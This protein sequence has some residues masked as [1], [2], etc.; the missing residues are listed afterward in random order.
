MACHNPHYQDQLKWVG[1]ATE[2]YLVTGTISGVTYNSALEQTTITYANATT[3]TNWPA[4][5]ALV[6]DPDWTNKSVSHPNR[7]LVLVHDKTATANTFIILS[8]TATQVVVKGKLDSNA[9]DPSYINPQTQEQNSPS[10]NTFGL[11]Y[12]DL[13]RDS[14]NAKPVKFF[15]PNGGFVEAGANTTG[16]C[17]VCHTATTRFTNDGT[18]PTGSDSHSSRVSGNCTSCHKHQDGFKG[19]SHDDTSF[20]WAGNCATCHNPNNTVTSIVNEIHG[21]CGLCHVDPAGGGARKDGDAAYGVDGSATGATNGSSCV[22]CHIAKLGLTAGGIHH[23]SK[24][25]YAAAADC[26]QCHA[27]TSGKLAAN[28]TAMVQGDANCVDCHTATAGTTAGVPVD[29][30]NAK[31]H[32]ACTTCHE[33]SG[34]LK[35]AYGLATAMPT[36]GTGSNDGGG[37][38]GACHGSYFSNHT[39]SHTLN[40][41]SLCLNCHV[42]AT[43][44]FVAAGEA[45]ANGCQTCHNTTT[46]ALVGDASGKGSGAD[47]TTCHSGY[48]SNHTHS[49]TMATVVMCVSCHTN[50]TAAPYVATGQIHALHGCTT[51]HSD[52]TG[53]LIGSATSKKGVPGLNCQTCHSTYFDGHG[54]DH[55][56][57]VQVNSATTPAVVNCTNCHV[58][59]A[60]PFVGDGEVHATLRCQSCHSNLN[61]TLIGSALG[62]APGGECG[63]CHTA[64]FG[65]HGHNHLV[66]LQGTD[67]GQAAPGASC[68]NCHTVGSWYAINQLHGAGTC[69]TCHNATRTTGNPSNPTETIGDVI[70]AN[71]NPTGCLACHWAKKS[72]AT[73][74]GH[75]ATAFVWTTA[76]QNSCGVAACHDSAVNANLVVNVHGNNCALCHVDPDHGNYTRRAGTDG[77]AIGVLKDTGASCDACHSPATYAT[78]TT[79]HD[80]ANATSGTCT[81]C[82]S[83]VTYGGNH[84]TLVVADSNCSGCHGGTAGTSTG[85]P[86]SASDNKVHDACTT[87]H[88]TTG[89]LKAAYGKAIAMPDGGAGSNNGGGV[90]TACHGSY[91]SN[92]VNADHST[93]VVESPNCSLC[94]PSP[95]IAG[96]VTGVPVDPANNKVHDACSTCHETNGT[97][98]AA[99]GKASAMPAGGGAC[100]ACHGD[101]FTKHTNANHS[102]RVLDTAN[103]NNCHPAATIAGTATGV[104]VDVN[105]NMVH[106]ACT[107]C[108]ATNGSLLAA[109]GKASTM[110]VGGGDCNA[111]HGL[112]FVNHS[113]AN[114]TTRVAT[115]ANCDSCHPSASIAGTTTGVPVSPTNNKVHDA[116]AT[117]HD[118]T[119]G[120]L[121]AAYG[122]ATAMPAGGGAC[123]ACHGSSFS[124]HSHG[125][126]MS[127][128]A[129]CTNCH[130]T[131][132]T[133]PFAAAGQ[134]H[135]R[136]GCQT[137]HSATGQLT[138]SAIG[139]T[140]GANCQTC[141]STYFNGHGHTHTMSTVGLCVS[142][143]TTATLAPY[144]A[145]GQTHNRLGCQ[146]CHSDT[147]GQRI[148]VAAGKGAGETCQTCHTAYFDGHGHNHGS[149]VK[150]NIATTPNTANCIGCHTATTAPFVAAGQV[151]AQLGCLSCH[152]STDGKLRG[153]ATEHTSGG[154]CSTCHSAYFNGH[155][156]HTGTTHAVLMRG[157]DLS[158]GAACNSCH[159]IGGVG[160]PKFTN[161]WGGASGIYAVH[162]SD[163]TLCHNS[164]RTTNVKVGYAGVQAII[165]DN[166]LDIGCLD[167]HGDRA[168]THGG[169]GSGDFIWDAAS[170]SGCGAA[171]C[172]NS[173]LNT[174]VVSSIHADQCALCHVSPTTG[175]Y[176]R[177]AGTDG[178]SVGAAVG[179]TCTNCHNSTTF[180]K[181]MIHHDT[182]NAGNGNCTV[183]HNGSTYGGNHTPVVVTDSNC[184]TCHP[185]TAGTAN[186]ILVSTSDN[187]VHDACTTCHE[188][189]GGLKAAYGKAIAMPAGGSASNDGGGTC[190]A[191]HGSYFP[192]HTNANHTTRVVESTNCNL[193]HLSAGIA[194]TVTG[195]P[196]DP[197]NNKVHDACSTCHQANGDLKAAYGKASAMPQGGGAC[198][199]CHG[200]Y[201][202][203]HASANH[204]A[205][206]LAD[207]NCV[208][209]HTGTAGTTSG[210]P[211]NAA[212]AKVHDGCSTCHE[213]NGALKAAYGQA[214]AMPVGGSGSNDGGGACSACHGSYFVSHSHSHT[215]NTVSL[216]LNCHVAAAAPYVVTGQ[217]HGIRGCQT[218]HNTTTGALIGDATGKTSG[219]DCSTCHGGYFNG[220]TH[221]HIMD[222]VAMCVSCHTNATTA[223]YSASGQIHAQA[224]CQ[225]CHD[226]ST[227]VLKGSATGKKGVTGI[228]CQTCH[229]AYF[230]GHSH[231]H[232][233][234]VKVNTATTPAVANCSNCHAATATPF[235]GVGQV[236]ATRGC[237]SC[238][239][240]LNGALVGSAQGKSPGGEC[241]D[242][243]TAYFSGHGHTHTVSLQATDL[244][245]A[246]PGALCTNCHAVGSWYATNQLHGL[247]TCSTC[248]NATRTTGNPNN[249]TETIQ[250]VI[251]ANA[252]PTG[253]LACHWA[254][255][256]PAT[257]GGH[258]ATAFVWTTTTQNSCGI[259]AC[260]NSAVNTNLVVDVHGNNCALC[261]VDPDHG[262][263]T[264]RAGTDGSA[265]GVLKDTGATC[266]ACH[267]TPTY[268]TGT[269]HHDTANAVSGACSAC[270]SG[271]TYGGNHTTL[272]AVDSDCSGCHAGTA[273]TSSGVP[274]STGDN[275]IHDTC[276]TCHET[277]GALKVAYGKAIAMPNGGAGSNNGGGNCTA[278]HGAY[279]V[280]HSNAN[281][282][283]R[284]AES[285]NCNLCHPTASIVG[286]TTGVPVEPA[287]NKVHD[288]CFTCHQSNG[289]LKAAYGNASAMPSG[290]G[291]CEACHGV[292]F[293]NHDN[294][295]HTTRVVDTAN[296]NTCHLTAT[297]AGTATGVPVDVADNKVHDNCATCHATNGSLRTAYGKVSAMPAG[298]GDCNACHGIYF[299]NHANANHTTR[300]ATSSTCDSC[301][302]PASI[303]GTGSGI[304]VDPVNN[305][306]HD[307]CTTCHN[308]TTGALLAAYGKASAMPTGGGT[309]VACH[310]SYFSG[311][312]H[313]HTMITVALCT[314]CHTTAT[315][316][317]YV[318]SGQ[319]HNR[320]GCQTCHSAT[321]GLLS[322]SAAGMTAGATCQTC[323]STYFNAHSHNH[324]MNTVAL[325]VSCHTTAT[326]APYAA[327]GQTHGRL[328]CQT[329]H[330]NTTGALSGA[331]AGQSANA[332]CQTCHTAYFNGHGHNHGTSVKVNSV[333]SVVTANCIGCHSATSAPFVGAGQ[334]H[335][336]QGCQSCHN[337]TDGKLRGSAVGHPVGGECSICHSTYFNGHTQHT[338]TTH[339]VLMRGSD[340]SGGVACNS[341]HA[342]G[343][344]GTPKFT[345]AWGGAAGIYALHR[346][347]CTLCHDS[348]R[349]INVKSGY[350]SVQAII[351]DN[352]LSI[353]CLDCH[354]DRG[355]TH[356]G[357]AAT[358]FIWDATS[359]SGCGAAACHNSGVNTDV[360][361]AIHGGQCVLC[362]TSPTTGDY[363]RRVGTDGTAVAA[364]L[365]AT[366]TTCHNSTTYPKGMIHHDTANATNGN[367]TSCHNG[368]T[369]GGNHTLL[370]NMNSNCATCH[371]ATA[372][373]A[374]GVPLSVADNKVHDACTTC[375][376]T[377][378]VLKAAYGSAIAMPAGTSASNDGGGTCT[379]CH[380]AYF[381]SHVN[382]NHTLR[383][384]DHSDCNACHTAT[385][386]TATTVPLSVADNKIHDTCGTCHDTTAGTLLAATTTSTTPVAPL[387]AWLSL[388][389]TAP[390]AVSSTGT[391]V[392]NVSVSAGSNR[393]LI[394]AVAMED[395]S[396]TSTTPT[397]GVTCGGTLLTPIAFGMSPTGREHAWLGYLKEGQIP[398]GS[399]PLSVSFTNGAQNVT[400]LHVK[401][402]SYLGVD[403][404]APIYGSAAT[405]NAA[406][407]VT[408]GQ[409]VNYLTSGKTLFVAVNG[410]AAATIPTPVSG[411]GASEAP[412]TANGFTS[413]ISQTATHANG[414]TYPNNT[415]V[416]FGGTTAAYS[417]IAVA[418][419]K[420]YTGS[421]TNYPDVIAIAPGTCVTCHGA[422]FTSHT[423]ADHTAMVAD[424]G[425]CNSC[426]PATA[427]AVT[428]VPVNASD[429]KVHDSCATCHDT[430]GTLKAAYGKASAMPVGGGDCNAC[431]GNYFATHTNANHLTRVVSSAN[432][433]TCHP[434]VSIAGTLTGIPV[435][436]A[437][438]KVHDA[439]S[440]CHNNTTG[441]LLA[442]YG[443]AASMPAGGGACEVCHSAYFAN[444]TH[445]H[446]LNTV[447]ICLNCHV[448]AAA[449]FA[450]AGEAHKNGC[451]TCHNTSTGALIGSA[452]GKTA[453]ADCQTCHS[454][455]FNSHG[456][457]HTMGTVAMCVSCHTTA[458]T[459]PYTAVAQTHAR[460]GCQT[461]HNAT[462]GALNGSATGKLSGA[463]CQTCHSTYFNGHAKDHSALVKVNTDVSLPVANCVNCHVATTAP[464]IGSG[465]AHANSSCQ[466]CHSTLNGTLQGSAVSGGGECITCHAAYFN[467]HSH[468]HTVVAQA[469]DLAQGSP[470]AQCSTCHAVSTWPA[471]A[472][473]HFGLCSTCHNETRLTGNLSNPAETVATVIAANANPTGCLACHWAKQTPA[474]HGGHSA[475]SFV[476]STAT[477]NSCGAAACHNSAAN[478][479]VVVA[480]HNNNC[481]LCHVNPNQGD[482]TRRAGIDGTAIGVLQNTG[483]S[484]DACHSPT[485]YPTGGAH[486]DTAWAVN[487]N[488]T[489]C[490]SGPTFGGN[491]VALVATDSNCSTAACHPGSAGTVSGVPVS[492]LDNKVHD[493]CTVC[494]ETNGVLKTAYG[495]AIAMPD[496]GVGSNNG[497]GTCTACHG[498]Y[499]PSHTNANH[500][501]RVVDSGNCNL[502]HLTATIVG[503][504]LGIPVLPTDPKVHDACTTCH[505]ANGS[506]RAAYGK[507]SAM[508]AGGGVCEVCHGAYFATHTNANHSTRVGDTANCNTCHAATAGTPAGVPLST[509]DN[510]VHDTCGV[511]HNSNGSLRAPY[512]S[513]APNM[514]AGGGTCN[515]CHAAYFVSHANAN[516]TARVA[517]ST[518]CIS[519][520]TATAGNL[521]SVP[522]NTSDNKVHDAC[523]TCHNTTTGVLLASYG[524][525]PNMAS[526]GGACEA[527]HGPYFTTHTHG[528]TLPTV[529]LCLNCHTATT[530]PYVASGQ[531]H[532]TLGCVTCHS[533]INGLLT[534]SALGKTAGATCSTCHSTYFNAHQHSHD[535]VTVPLCISCHTTATT[536]PYAATGQTHARLGC[537][538]CH[539]NS[540]GTRIGSAAGKAKGATCQTCHS[541]YFDGHTHNHGTKMTANVATT[542][543]TANCKGCH[544]A[545]TAPFI[546]AGQ[547][548]AAIGCQ[549]CHDTAANGALK[550][551]ATDQTG[552]NECVTCH[553]SYFT[554]HQV[555][556][557]TTHDVLMRVTDLSGGLVCNTCHKRGGSATTNPVFTNTWS[558]TDGLLALHRSDCGLCHNSTRTTNV[559]VGFTSV[560]N[561]IMTGATVACLNCHADRAVEHGGHNEGD[562][563][564][565]WIASCQTCH[566]PSGISSAAPKGELIAGV[567]SANC[568]KCH[569]GGVPAATLIGS[570]AN[571]TWGAKPHICTE[572]HTAGFNGH[573]HGANHDVLMRTG[574]RVNN[575]A[576]CNECHKQG[577]TSSANPLFTNA[578]SGTDGILALHLGSCVV[579]HN[580]T[581][582]TNLNPSY[583]SVSDVIMNATTVAC[584]D[585]HADRA[586][587]HSSHDGG[588][589]TWAG[590]CGN[591]HTGANI[592]INVHK[593]QCGLCHLNANGGGTLRA[594]TDGSALLAQP[595]ANPRTASC[596]DCHPLATYPTG[597]IHH[598]TR[599]AATNDCLTCHININHSTFVTNVAPCSECHTTT[600]GTATGMPVDM[601]NGRVHD[602]CRTCHTFNATTLAGQ[603]VAPTGKKGVTAMAIGSC[604]SCH[605]NTTTMHH[606]NGHAVIGE[607]EYCHAD[608]RNMA[609]GTN[610]QE[611]APGTGIPTHL[612]CEECHVK[613]KRGATVNGWTATAGQMTIYA[614]NEGGSHSTT[615]YS[616]D[617]VRTTAHSGGHV[618][619][620]TV[621][622]INNWGICFS[623]HDGMVGNAVRVNL[624]HAKP[625]AI[626]ATNLS[627]GTT[628]NLR[629]APGREA[630][631]T[632]A[633]FDFFASTFRPASTRP[634]GSGSCKVAGDWTGAVKYGSS[635][636]TASDLVVPDPWSTMTNTLPMFPAQTKITTVTPSA[637]N[638]KVSSAV[639]TG[640]N[641]VVTAT[642]SNGCTAL[643][644]SYNGN[645]QAFTGSGICTA[646]FAPSVVYTTTVKSVSVTTTNTEGIN[647]SGYLVTDTSSNP[648][649]H[650]EGD[651]TFTWELTCQGCHGVGSGSVAAPKGEIMAGVHGS[652]CGFCHQGGVGGNGLIGSATNATGK[653][654][655]HTCTEC[656]V[657]YF[658]THLH[659]A[660]HAVLMRGT[661]LSAGS[662]CNTCH[663][664]GGT[665]SGNALFTNSWSGT[666]GIMAL[667]QLGCGEC[668]SST[669][670]TN[671]GAG[672]TSV[673]NV[674]MTGTNVGCLDCHASRS[675]GH[676]GHT[677]GDGTFAWV[678]SCQSCHGSGSASTAAPQ[679]DVI[680]GVHGGNCALCHQ[681]GIGG[682]TLIGSA[683]NSNLAPRPHYCTDCHTTYFDSHQHGASHDVQMRAGDL[684][685]GSTCNFCHRVGGVS[686]GNPLFTNTWTG[687]NGILALHQLGCGECHNSTRTTNVSAGFTSVQDVILRGTI[688]SCQNCHDNRIASHGRHAEGDGSFTWD[689]SCQS[690]HG[691]GSA[692][693]NAP[694]G[695]I[696]A[697]VHNDNCAYCHQ[698]GVG[699]G[700]LIGSA[701]NATVG[702]KPHPCSE[703]HLG[704]FTAHL[705]GT[706]HVV[707]M[708]G[709]DIANG[710][711]CNTCHRRAGTTSANPLFTNTWSGTDGILALHQ[712]GCTECH[713]STRTTNVKAPYTSVSDVILS[714]AGA[715]C[716][717]CHA[718]REAGHASHYANDFVW[719]GTCNTC[720]TG[721]NIMATVHKANCGLCHVNPA[722]GGARKSGTD[723]NALLGDASGLHRLATCLTCHPTATYPANKIHHDTRSAA[724]N[725]CTT[726]HTASNHA[727]MVN[728]T[729]TTCVT[730]HT[731]TAG[732]ASGAPVSM[733]DGKV[734]DTCR[735]CHTFY[736]NLKGVLVAATNKRGVTTMPVGGTATNDGGGLCTACHTTT[737][738]SIHHGNAHAAI[739]ECEWCHT[740]PRH[741][742]GGSASFLET[743]PAG[744]IPTHLPC[745]ECHVTPKLGATANGWTATAGQMTIY[746]FNEGG[747]HST[748]D[749]TTD[750]TRTVAHSGGHVITNTVGKINNWGICFSCHGS[751]TAAQVNHFHAKPTAITATNLSCGTTGNL[752]YAPGREAQNTMA[753]FDFFASTFRPASTR[754]GGSGSCKVAGDWTGAV[755]YGSTM[756]TASDL[757][758]PDPW[759]TVTNTLPMFPAQT[760]NTT[761]TP[762]A[763]DVKV[764]S[765]TW[766][767]TNIV[768]TATNTSGCAALTATY[769]GNNQVFSGTGTCT[770]SFAGSVLYTTSVT[771][772][773]VT[774]SNTEGVSVNGY[775]IKDQTVSTGAHSEGDGTF[776]WEA[777][778]QTCHDLAST[779][780]AA[781]KGEV[782]AGVHGGNCGFCHQ[783]GVAG[784]T[785]IGSA[786]QATLGAKPHVCTECHTGYFDSHTHGASTTHE[787]LMRG[788]DLAGTAACNTCHR[789]GGTATANPL[790]TNSWSG[791]DGIMALHQLGCAECHDSTRTT[792]VKAPY[793]SV[794]NV[795]MTGTTVGC[796][797][798]HNDRSVGHGGHN[799]TDFVWAGNC[800]NCHT[801]ADITV[802]VHRNN[803]ADCHVNPAGGGTRRAGVDGS[804]LLGDASGLHRTATC[805]TCHPTATYPTGGIHHDTANATNGNCVSCHSGTTYGGNHTTLVATVSNCSSCHT[806]IAGTA[807]GVPVNPADNKVHDA[808]LTCHETTG[809]LK[810]AYGRATAMPNGGA[811]SNNG[812]GNCTACHGSYFN[813]HTHGHTMNTVSL[814]IGCH[815]TATTAPYVAAGQ[816]HATLGCA[817]CHNAA[818][819][820]LIGSAVGKTAGANCQ[821]CHSTY[822]NGH[823]HNHGTTV[824]VNSASTPATANCIGCHAATSSPFIG[825][826]QVHALQGCASCHNTTN[827]ALKGSATGKTTGGEC[828]T[829][830]VGYFT[831]HTQHTS[832]THAVLMRAGDLSNSAA[833]N[834]C[835]RRGGTASANPL[836]TNTWTGTDGIYALHSGGCAMCHDSTR[837]TNLGGSYTS[838]SNVIMTA[839][840]PACLDCH[841][842]RATGHGSHN[843][844]DFVWAG[845]CNTCHTGT[846]IMV[847]VHKA[848]CGLCHVNPAG[849]GA[850]KVGTDG[851]ALLGD[852]SGLHRLATCLTCHPAAT[853]PLDKIHHDTTPVANNACTTC[854]SAANHS[855]MV[856][857][858]GTTCINCHTATAGT[859]SGAPVN[860][861]DGKIHDTCR[862]CHTFDVNL[863][864]VLVAATNNRGV[865]TM[866]VGGTGTNDGGGLCTV[867]HTAAASTIHHGNAHAAI[868]E[869]EWCHTDPRHVSG[870]SASFLETAPAGGIP[871]HLPCEECHVTPKLGATANGW[872]ASAGQMTIY[873]FNEG[874][875][876]STTDYTSDFTRTVAH[877]GGHVITNT[878]G[879]INNW[880]ICFSCHGGGTAAQVNHFH[881]KPTAITAT[882]LSCGTTGNLRYAPP[883]VRQVPDPAAQVP[884]KWLGIGPAP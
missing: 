412:A 261:H 18:M 433:A 252:N 594:G 856:N 400:G 423:H 692:S 237:Q 844:T 242:C 288:E 398:S 310:G 86:L 595:L 153:S 794:N 185:N 324:A 682:A 479:D 820:V 434:A 679:G 33:T 683:T 193:C 395:A 257:H 313:G 280:N 506:L 474:T 381:A 746:A 290:G 700:V 140:A 822:F 470:G 34:A 486:H 742:S 231:N 375:H 453:G 28:H 674:I 775:R 294:A 610:F 316:A 345:N 483:A 835:H 343:S 589:F 803:C 107:T 609:G 226:N 93:R 36:G 216:C 188:T 786:S 754:P 138:G 364:V 222:T 292:Y 150:V 57:N 780:T 350:A 196:V 157:V 379:A 766:N 592:A 82:H 191:C 733:S 758:V 291:A 806:A 116:C 377:S 337:S 281:H 300:V 598:N 872:T 409:A 268:P 249:P 271:T 681:N 233:T 212:D 243:H 672:Y 735:T 739:G 165:Q 884:V 239:D 695:E 104:P 359:Q 115:S 430:N 642:N 103:C 37:V 183:C 159:G 415:P 689:S 677:E 258:S 85:V 348:S 807:T 284:V 331:A 422:Y 53:V 811:G 91:F 584:V 44:P 731:L 161:A 545:T 744:G 818:T 652:N 51:C 285:A 476:W 669:R 596:L 302:A 200:I 597:G 660:T 338:T 76:T 865:T 96:T 203:N 726:C 622:Q 83:G 771:T 505:N 770:A 747:S 626:T 122:K 431:H 843:A 490:H 635:N 429:N 58:A 550:G 72:P 854:H 94:H 548:H 536:A 325:C 668:H 333:T 162:R 132:T 320:L 269:I 277:N 283:T 691:V 47:C 659:G 608:P 546:G 701:T 17:Q 382:I 730:C 112:Y 485:T 387:D 326:S 312:S 756:F 195:I 308:A 684:S 374:T 418:S 380:G 417:A 224:G 515:A 8:A 757:V 810:A 247:G 716:L 516:H 293:A 620:N 671:V 426:H 574:D 251:N 644:A 151:H 875:S 861:T 791:T 724:N 145:V 523:A 809:V 327:S 210:V 645:N 323:H 340:L 860:L 452:N 303:A 696:I 871:T 396:G 535:M 478:T 425:N 496:G 187:K 65:G 670:T 156:Q 703:C 473:L 335:A 413:M 172:H 29:P 585:C 855:S 802:D 55:S 52:T 71:A 462:T 266:D 606:S 640:T 504:A 240:T 639:W 662:A 23:N 361:V 518:S 265:I 334:V 646:T 519:C 527:C 189:S 781:P 624:F 376:E 837:T 328:G 319:T 177:R 46:G 510:K 391:T 618:I 347:D 130:T 227:G 344:V 213:D 220:H 817:T 460:L 472:T 318:A 14:I 749:Y 776:T 881:A 599:T 525:A 169:H 397:I 493:A 22:D 740:D 202:V 801:G 741:V 876:H 167:C 416:T 296:C 539:S 307:A 866:P 246:A 346:S 232:S 655:P 774:T 190:T 564:F 54:H 92:H 752:R 24:S 349:T 604:T 207:T 602:S 109:Y 707:T 704:Y 798:C 211:V 332:D 209:C 154:E 590:I 651:G 371:P 850:R 383:V 755:K 208:N 761:T 262:N 702:V 141:H 556:S 244:G 570:A 748:T 457:S 35:A 494:H 142:C 295:N 427:G 760:A 255:K 788:T 874:G 718:D 309:C 569:Q 410:G 637:D 729:G 586:A 765:A 678:A 834:T 401:W 370:V 653:P 456:H 215:L 705:R 315:T 616:T 613:P 666:D 815:T 40:T 114:H 588:D 503:T 685:A 88:Q 698:G 520:H 792:N 342:I 378:G 782:I 367:C 657:G 75:T 119:T 502:C 631:N 480:V 230:N 386:G 360:V 139:Q 824:R 178:S 847:T 181:G 275:K 465:E 500:L 218:C 857:G 155:T 228:N 751:G 461:C 49:H 753:N 123:E 192:S 369:Y 513:K 158:G 180:P 512:S 582:T 743:A 6:N 98:K 198:E 466:T 580:S 306:V 531:A 69:S 421:T 858:T 339:A 73:H 673:A 497:G 100:E 611:T 389:S 530:A 790:F 534:G 840:A 414:G 403:Q 264:R 482:Y 833:C 235:V 572:C 636:Y 708:K 20:A 488:C 551:S 137:C 385:S 117:C 120:V 634:G 406:A 197:A 399:S 489:N 680:D 522:V 544:S 171:A 64:Y 170:Q 471:I 2:P 16:V 492:A 392:G 643:T 131:A 351:N 725:D 690:C 779:S 658:D 738:A 697:G 829:C 106:D 826:G 687:T 571:A 593:G 650:L 105:N 445:S 562:G 404:T 859:A 549:T 263:Y 77:S 229:G 60:T 205:V 113:N 289:I 274:L 204:T 573:S 577:G 84:T 408:F 768:V 694:Q 355:A 90:C 45:H 481:A 148:S 664:R 362:H 455:Y 841:A 372:G 32:D 568:G 711:A 97:L 15:D 31:V 848:N 484:C 428:G 804:S 459:A 439:C 136:L 279:F 873:A 559:G 101:Y 676:G 796:L 715:G 444:H 68:L 842:D 750:F 70:A 354:S 4:V 214:I 814:C 797:D 102:T 89:P 110:P 812:G 836:F 223:P 432:C 563:S 173:T 26:T 121:L 30:V 566:G 314:N 688:V 623:C 238:H 248:H 699:G 641:I 164:T 621:G 322:G 363:T 846:N 630:Q 3:N 111:C 816:T 877:S 714:A 762:A 63:D 356:G 443:K 305:K 118:T 298:G 686:S 851:S 784:A 845:T 448:A 554:G 783:G 449:P 600:A 710:A 469:T 394:V 601:A 799:P 763:D 553:S 147:S 365:G 384:A 565:A 675:A 25:G 475:T 555:H 199:V 706:S 368:A 127:T 373:T 552:N 168:V 317:P 619:G 301:H 108:H 272:V 713:D 388:S 587:T 458:T 823:T 133:A 56:T 745:E 95:T 297:I 772:L 236:H 852:A 442:A 393:V 591:C 827:G 366:C 607:C 341:C 813:N 628:G 830:H 260:H 499:F 273:G 402:A 721:S 61:G 734:H 10:C 39:H 436:P 605:T 723:G 517:G 541:T 184:A 286:T 547:V 615:D 41:V 135:S 21:A 134:T 629:Y 495:T 206:V 253:C 267:L 532:A 201:F 353:G 62:K 863:K 540:T 717:D 87:C 419:L 282:T 785:L 5:G 270:H 647:V 533:N 250:D 617:F 74:G 176:T 276:T 507:A 736:A 450:T 612:P 477:Q 411:F 831:G 357:H 727:A 160:T 661:D 80:T 633:N 174:D 567:H 509:T 336:P 732:T 849:G 491:H 67:L 576:F 839:T 767:G 217:A 437:N 665:G 521:T 759:S 144:T 514:P 578:W 125:H 627:C 828:V 467:G 529:S 221:N 259:A 773:N 390:N 561:V 42:A 882:N 81:A 542:P 712:L 175:D 825:V 864:G 524:K 358:D 163:C 663:R 182:T 256:S 311:H 558:G 838:V 330:S 511:C 149:S 146:T 440:T 152:N 245:Q 883:S 693:V 299:V 66:A 12:G 129:M 234:N 808:C 800:N 50:A 194:G 79:H 789:R 7:G 463:T 48:F 438:N 528:H 498:T 543:N 219:A 447:S 446:A 304:P 13:I 719:A 99:Y 560:N 648:L 468:N 11:I 179:A 867:C 126:S 603:L 441:A 143:H 862:T 526:P 632:M 575:G 764:V 654:V 420:P 59:T 625:G 853:Y 579:C 709:T 124:G 225:T 722:G 667:H 832:T 880:G 464:F 728:A 287:N 254:K 19:G 795:I 454:G 329:C 435:D 128:V 241:A 278:C 352:N 805:L 9:V 538:T 38:C 581:R 78:G 487:G 557:T 1:S 778:C 166:N 424:T 737:S 186:G 787:V 27:A 614:F 870:G 819:G 793:T 656:H 868:G 769:N 638:V 869:C 508:P 649:G 583:T 321:T 43:A 451:Q 821:T 777:N 501:S 878:V 405:Y 537:Q 407:N 879:Q 720:H